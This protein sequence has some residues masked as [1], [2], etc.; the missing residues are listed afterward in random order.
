VAGDV[1]AVASTSGTIPSITT[2]VDN[3]F[4]VVVCSS[5]FDS[6]TGQ[7]SGFTNAA[8]TGLAQR[9]NT[10]D[11]AG[12]GGG[13]GVAAGVK[14]VAGAVG[15]TSVTLANSSKQGRVAFALKPA[16]SSNPDTPIGDLGLPHQHWRLLQTNAPG[17]GP[18]FN[19]I[20]VVTRDEVAG[21]S[22]SLI[23]LPAKM[24]P[25]V[26]HVSPVIMVN[27][28]DG[29]GVVDIDLMTSTLPSGYSPD[30]FTDEVRR[31][32]DTFYDTDGH[33]KPGVVQSDGA[34]GL[35]L[36]KG[37]Q[38][39]FARHNE[40]ITFRSPYQAV[41]DIDIDGGLPSQ[42]ESRW[43]TAAGANADL[44]STAPAG[45]SGPPSAS[46]QAPEYSALDATPANFRIRAR[47]RQPGPATL[48]TQAFPGTVLDVVDEA[49]QVI[50][51]PG[52]ANNDQYI[53]D[54]NSF[55]TF[56]SRNGS[57]ASVRLGYVIETIDGTSNPVPRFTG[58]ASFSTTSVA[59]VSVS[60][61]SG[62][63]ITV[64]GLDPGDKIQIRFTGISMYGLIEVSS[65]STVGG[66]VLYYT[67]SADQ[68]ASKTPGN[69]P[70]LRV[71][72]NSKGY[73]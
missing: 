70:D 53:V 37:F 14:T 12:N 9:L 3:C 15:T 40:V 69:Y 42:P 26:D 17:P 60:R 25:G 21:D 68:Y 48:Q 7:F 52:L 35:P 51:S 24:H 56:R 4:V 57:A 32:G 61:N 38:S 11:D 19:Q 41:P 18:E 63:L 1:A 10:G 30:H 49:V 44:V 36:V 16:A 31:R 13:F 45:A 6:L 34:N 67:S 22:D 73:L 65:Y 54:L 23:D 43:G 29:N 28:P 66:S 5:A 55:L 33:L 2:T 71:R 47:L 59:F 50:L 62:A 46:A 8:L 72:W 27:W 39:G 64:S 58:D 20:E